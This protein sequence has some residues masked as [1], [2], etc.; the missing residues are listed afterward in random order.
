MTIRRTRDEEDDARARRRRGAG[1]TRTTTRRESARARTTTTTTT[2][3]R[4]RERGGEVPLYMCLRTTEV[5]AG[6][7]RAVSTRRVR[8]GGGAERAERSAGDVPE[9]RARR[10]RGFGETHGAVSGGGGALL[11]VGDGDF[12]FSL[13]LARAFGGDGVVATSYDD[14][15]VVESV[16]G[17]SCAR[18]LEALAET[19]R[20][21][22]AGDA[23]VVGRDVAGEVSR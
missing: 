20:R 21:W 6:R 22:R 13:A 12:S 3:E 14:E 19:E 7:V 8:G 9:I 15:G 5:R 11:T 4:E 1:A 18:T 23:K 10:A 2:R 17:E 16:Y